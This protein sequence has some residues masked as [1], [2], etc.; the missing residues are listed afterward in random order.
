MVVK[1][2]LIVVTFLLYRYLF[3]GR[4]AVYL[5]WEFR[6]VTF[7]LIFFL[8]WVSLFLYLINLACFIWVIEV[9]SV[10]CWM[11]ISGIASHFSEL[12]SSDCQQVL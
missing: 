11:Y 7:I 9:W 4:A 3:F 12:I 6:D 5:Q 10:V 1:E 8:H 2:A